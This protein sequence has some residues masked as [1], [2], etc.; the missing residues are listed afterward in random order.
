MRVERMIAAALTVAAAI[1]IAGGT[2][3]ASQSASDVRAERCQE[4]LA[5]IAERRGVSVAELEARIRAN[6]LARIDAALAAGRITEQKAATLRE[7]VA[8]GRLCKLSRAALGA[9]L[10]TRALLRG[11]AAYLGLTKAQLRAQLRGTS[12][13]ALA[14]AQ[15][16]PVAG[17]KAAMLASASERLAAAVERG[18][19]T[20]ARADRLLERLERRIDRLVTRVFPAR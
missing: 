8:A 1:L 4:R 12:L 20:Q 2:A 6:A 19:M 13:A 18:R 7:R 5:R 17:L 16:K 9:K 10:G 3:F 15:G 11:A 14:Q